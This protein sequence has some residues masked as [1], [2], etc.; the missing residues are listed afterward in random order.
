MKNKLIIVIVCILLGVKS[1]AQ[2]RTFEQEVKGIATSLQ[3]NTIKEKERLKIKVDSLNVLVEKELMTE[4][5][6]QKLKEQFA[7]ES[8][9]RIEIDANILNGN[10]TN[11]VQTQVKEALTS[12]DL[13]VEK[14][15]ITEEYF[16]FYLG[17]TPL[18]KRST[19]NFNKGKR[20]LGERRTT[21]SLFFTYGM[22][23]LETNGAFANSEIRYI[24]SNFS[25]FGLFVKTRLLKENNAYYLRYGIG[26]EFNNLKPTDHRYFELQ[27]GQ[28]TITDH[29]KNLGKS[30]LYINSWHLPL[31][32]EY[33]WS[34]P[35]V[36][37]DTGR[38]YYRSEKIWRAGIGGYV[39]F[40]PRIMQVY[41]YSE[42]GKDYRVEQKSD[43]GIAKTRFGLGS[44]IGYRSLALHF[45]YELTPLFKYN[46]VKQN[47]W[48]LGLRL[49]L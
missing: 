9:K 14:D 37:E 15:S 16:Q 48:S 13:L 28:T 8:A 47:M 6:A 45:Q 4:E 35:I 25:Q 29:E 42:E 2:E 3:N 34:K 17:S 21:F 46:D 39:N 41:H 10:L 22:T 23:N 30:R 40:A 49:D 1:K 20:N 5:K 38:V 11:L 19:Y 18:G 33:D 26:A 31:Y 24:P 36:N 44:Y 32:F 7:Q 12:G 27:N 43:L